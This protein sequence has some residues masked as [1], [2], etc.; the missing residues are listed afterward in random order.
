MIKFIKKKFIRLIAIISMNFQTIQFL[1]EPLIE[2]ALNKVHEKISTNC[3]PKGL[4]ELIS[5]L[6]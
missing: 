2:L 5:I 6:Y 1:K 3:E 4:E